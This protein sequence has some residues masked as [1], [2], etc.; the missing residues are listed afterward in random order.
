M[1]RLFSYALF[2]GVAIGTAQAA[3]GALASA[4]TPW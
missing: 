1:I 4:V 3:L 2:F